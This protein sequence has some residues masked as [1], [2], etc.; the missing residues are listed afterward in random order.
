MICFSPFPHSGRGA[1]ERDS[2][3]PGQLR[4]TKPLPSP[5]PSPAMREREQTGCIFN[6]RGDF[7]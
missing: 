3:P 4:K 5:K 6:T 7:Q 2:A 1:G